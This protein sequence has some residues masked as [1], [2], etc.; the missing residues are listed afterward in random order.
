M[1]HRRWRVLG[2]CVVVSALL[3]GG[4]A[5]SEGPA[6]AQAKPVVYLTFDGGPGPS[7][8]AFLALLARHRVPATF[9]VVGNRIAGREESVRQMIRRGHSI[10]N[11]SWDHPHLPTLTTSGII[12]QFTSG[13]TTILSTTRVRVAC[14]RPPYGDTN[15][16]VH[17][18]AVSVGLPNSQWVTA[19]NHWGLWDVDT[20]D[21]QLDDP[22][23]GR[24][25]AD[26]LQRLNQVGDGDTVLLHD[27][28]IDRSR[29]LAV[30][31]RW[32]TA[33]R[34]R[35]EFRVLPGCGGVLHEQAF[36]NSRPQYWHRFQIARLY[37]AY[38]DRQPDAGGWDYWNR[39]YSSWVPLTDISWSFAASAE[40][41]LA[42]GRDDAEFVSFIYREVLDRE[43]DPGG[44]QYWRDQLSRGLSRGAMVL[45]F[46]ES[47]EFIER[48]V[49]AV[50]GGCY[51]GD[52]ETSYRCLAA[53]LPPRQ[54]W[55]R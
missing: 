19:G 28:P 49:Q 8:P 46:S 7:T 17:D 13:T 25:E 45:Y 30:L 24:T 4:L 47:L 2:A 41:N 3:A 27:G 40:F 14:Y 44:F 20:R 50:T 10:G 42:G 1:G 16:R 36:D 38:F 55:Q 33:N 52:V 32:L 9:F 23:S 53:N 43:P 18:A 48:T 54:Q 39:V 22:E 21:W 5:N 11:H 26:V 15:A 31:D 29:G 12:G 35:F 37:R 34:D 51:L 6:A